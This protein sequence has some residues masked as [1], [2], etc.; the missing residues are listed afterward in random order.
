MS[1]S[2]LS[3]LKSGI[4]SGTEEALNLSSNLIINSSYETNFRHKL[5]LTNTQV[6]RGRKAFGNGSLAN[7]ELS[8]TEWHKIGQSGGFLNRILGPLLKTG[9]SLIKNV[10]KPF[11]K[12]LLIPLGLTAVASATNA[13][14]HKKT[15]GSGTAT[16]IISKI[17]KS[18][19]ESGL[20]T[21]VVRETINNEAKELKGWFLAILLH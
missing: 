17:N 13:A 15:S 19:E 1:N 10:L 16:L 9:F 2:Q 4:K 18:L 20:L 3:K 11:P 6:L 14:I 5:L 8:K 7:I 21:R 12:S